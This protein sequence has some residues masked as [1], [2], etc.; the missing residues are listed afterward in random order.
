M[1]DAYDVRDQLKDLKY[2]WENAGKY[3]H[4]EVLA[5]GF[6]LDALLEQPWVH[7]GVRVDVYSETGEL[8]H[9]R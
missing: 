3:W 8:L 2:R 6:S 7:Q 5:E 1:F 4:R 9:R